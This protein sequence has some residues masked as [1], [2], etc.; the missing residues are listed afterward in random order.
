MTTP[1]PTFPMPT[2]QEFRRMTTADLERFL[3]LYSAG[4]SPLRSEI[5]AMS[6]SLKSAQWVL[7]GIGE[8]DI[9]WREPFSN[10]IGTTQQA[11][12]RLRGR[13]Q[14]HDPD[15]SRTFPINWGPAAN[16]V[17]RPAPKPQPAKPTRP[18]V[19]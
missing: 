18:I 15:G 6:I 11:Y 12:T 4:V 8:T 19:R 16:V 7:V 2:W 9:S 3:H 17:G 13:Q 10:W 5:I 14:G 1:D